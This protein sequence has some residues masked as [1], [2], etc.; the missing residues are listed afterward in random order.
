MPKDLPGFYFDEAKNRYFPLS[1]RPKP[2][3]DVAATPPVQ[4][5]TRRRRNAALDPSRNMQG[6]IL[7]SQRQR[8]MH[9]IMCSQ[10]A[11]TC[12]T[13][14]AT[15]PALA[16]GGISAFCTTNL[17]GQSRSYLG[18]TRGWLYS[19]TADESAWSSP[20]SSA[21]FQTTRGWIPELNLSS[22]IS[23][24][25][26]S[27]S[28]CVASSFGPSCKVFV[29]DMSSTDAYI[30]HPGDRAIHDSWR[31]SLCGRSLAIGAND[32]AIVIE[33]ID[34]TR[35]IRKLHTSSD[36]FA[37]HQQ[38]NL[39]YT[40]ARNGSIS[41]FDMRL[42]KPFGQNLLQ[43]TP[44][45]ASSVGFVSVTH[46]A[47]IHEWQLLV[48]HMNGHMATFDLRFPRNDSPTMTLAEPASVNVNI[49]PV[50]IDPSE[51]FVFAA[52]RDR[53]ICAWSLRTGEALAPSLASEESVDHPFACTFESTV[54]TLQVVD[55]E[56]ESGLCL[57]AAT[58][59]YLYKYHLGQYGR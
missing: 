12:R 44:S 46:L 5:G 36:V 30:L 47:V 11:R 26:M 45:M 42:N 14:R 10:I 35:S 29:Q 49:Y 24:I 6:V 1:S 17:G 53:R 40:G 39:V 15:V 28:I 57:W 33:D 50:A 56:G 54:R 8:L 41:R 3:V 32:K 16:S 59:D 31:S 20:V 4:Q 13:T 27:G 38:P 22:G 21:E 48:A 43:N 52:C 25:C 18:D 34:S 51:Q 7:Y 19:L 9:E 2:E 23:S 58:D 37:V 55:E